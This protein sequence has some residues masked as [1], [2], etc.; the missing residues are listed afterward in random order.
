[1]EK[2]GSDQPKWLRSVWS[3]TLAVFIVIVG[4]AC[5]IGLL[6]SIHSFV[7]NQLAVNEAYISATKIIAGFPPGEQ[8]AMQASIDHLEQLQIIQQNAVSS[9][10]MAFIYSVLSSVLVGLCAGFVAN[11]RKSAEEAKKSSL[12]AKETIIAV[13]AEAGKVKEHADNAGLAADKAKGNADEARIIAEVSKT[14]VEE[15]QESAMKAQLSYNEALEQIEKQRDVIEVLGIH[16]EIVHVRASLFKV[17]KVSIN[18]R[19]FNIQQSVLALSADLDRAVINQLQQELLSLFSAI[20]NIREYM[21]SITDEREKESLAQAI[22]RYERQ[23]NEAV[24]H[25][26]MLLRPPNDAA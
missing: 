7:T 14:M 15:S 3:A 11:G 25:C 8:E 10:M 19:M 12:D 26:D 9:G 17:D 20:E 18:K 24:N 6:V 4:V 5:L 2:N 23:L 22:D 21:D 16:I 13:K 1:M